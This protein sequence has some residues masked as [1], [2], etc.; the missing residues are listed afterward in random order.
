M[1]PKQILKRIISISNVQR[2][3]VADIYRPLANTIRFEKLES[4]PAFSMFRSELRDALL[5]SGFIK[6]P[7]PR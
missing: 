4:V 3:S 7:Y 1:D 5:Y 6:E 2:L